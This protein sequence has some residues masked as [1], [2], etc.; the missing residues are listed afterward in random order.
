MSPDALAAV[1]DRW[2]GG[3]GAPHS[4][5][6]DCTG[7]VLRDPPSDGAVGEELP[8]YLQSVAEFLAETDDPPGRVIFPELL[9]AG[10]IMLIHGEPRSRKSLAAFELALSAATG[11]PPF[12]LGRFRPTE[13]V[14][15]LYVQ[16]EDPRTLTRPRIRR[17]VTER[18]GDD[19]PGGL[20]VSVR[21]GVNLDDPAWVGRLIADLIRLGIRLLVLDAARRLSAKTDEGPVKVREFTSVLRRIVNE[22][23]VTIVVVHH[24][25]KP[26]ATGP[27]Q[28]R[29]SQRA[30][31]ADWFAVSECPVHVER[32]GASESLFFPEDYKFAADPAPFMFTC[33]T[34]G[35]LIARLVGIDTTSEHAERAGV[36]G[37]VLEWLRANGPATKS[38]M[39]RAGLGRW[40][41]I[42]GALEYLEKDGKVDS[43]PGRK[44]GSLRYFVVGGTVPGSGDD[45]TE[46]NA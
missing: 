18:C 17:L 19:L 5:G 11:T 8:P 16:E 32:I 27:D 39:K 45:S 31:G 44:A 2:A 6:C 35:E 33:E 43:A 41:T 23:G 26:P 4:E 37:K 3:N 7:C 1:L 15:T 46:F 22:T 14:P 38:D 40:E 12:G 30:S 21:R 34:D 25:V 24:D 36:R 20:H 13:A 42:E 29:R 28:R 9:P 10:V